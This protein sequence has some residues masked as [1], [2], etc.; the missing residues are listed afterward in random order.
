MMSKLW[1]L[2]VFFLLIAST[3]ARSQSFTFADTRPE[4]NID[5]LSNW[6]DKNPSPS[7]LRLKNLI[8]IERSYRWQNKH[9]L[10]KHS[11]E[12][13]QLSIKLNSQVGMASYW[14]LKSYRFFN[15]FASHNSVQ[16]IKKAIHTF[17]LLNDTS[18]L[19]HSYCLQIK[20]VSKTFGTN[21]NENQDAVLYQAYKIN[22]S[23]L[24]A[25]NT[26]GDDMMEYKDALAYLS[27][28]EEPNNYEKIQQICDDV[29]ALLQKNHRLQYANFAFKTRLLCS[30][31]P[32]MEEKYIKGL[33]IGKELM[34]GLNKNNIA[35][36]IVTNYN[37]ALPCVH[38]KKYDEAY[39][40]C[41][42]GLNLLQKFEPY[43]FN[44][45]YS[46]YDILFQVTKK[47]KKYDLAMSYSDSL[48]KYMELS[49]V[50][51]N[52]TKM[53]ELQSIYEFEKKQDE[54]KHLMHQN[55]ES[56]F[57]QKLYLLL[58]LVS[59]ALVMVVTFFVWKLRKL[60]EELKTY[61]QAKERLFSIIAHDLRRPMAAFYDMGEMLSFYVQ[62]QDFDALAIVTKAID[63]SSR[64]MR[65]M[66]DNLLN[67]ALSEREE[68]PYS[69]EQINLLEIIKDVLE[70][71]HKINY[72]KKVDFVVECPPDLYVYADK[73][74]VELILRNLIDNSFFAMT[75][76]GYIKIR[77]IPEGDGFAKIQVSDNAGG[78]SPEKLKVIYQ[79]FKNPD[80]AV[81]GK[82][83]M[84]MG[85]IMLARF[86][87][88][89]KG[90]IRVDT[91]H[92]G[93]IFSIVLPSEKV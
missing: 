68:L 46:Y 66:L 47:Q 22:T 93:S 65:Q 7:I 20:I 92:E 50:K 73:R 84:G 14:Y 41:I 83:G 5:S 31:G 79:V 42:E 82:N 75:T 10:G 87:I 58:A 49:Y 1:L 15:D 81:I 26:N 69:P 30:Y 63:D 52:N 51:A 36:K 53:L 27:T 29:F 24:M 34:A 78:I 43:N 32:G 44:D 3:I 88:K 38:L 17:S 74:G 89:N 4:I 40:Y 56:A 39:L 55:E 35:E 13:S 76:S 37:M 61:N 91:T 23:Q 71:Y 19:V 90:H 28:K 72:F 64:K 60:N 70:V 2:S 25:Q 21:G 12:I 16:F 85:I 11:A 48:I 57:R 9:N 18:G 45:F 54:I 62:N 59:I 80:R 8:K 6:L 77:A 67:W 33:A 86:V